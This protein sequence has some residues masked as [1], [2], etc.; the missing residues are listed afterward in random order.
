MTNIGLATVAVALLACLF[1]ASRLTLR[2]RVCVALALSAIQLYIP[3]GWFSLA[4][5]WCGATVLVSIVDRI[6]ERGIRGAARELNLA[7]WLLAFLAGCQ[8]VA[9]RWSPD[10]AQALGL[11]FD[12][13]WFTGLLLVIR[14]GLPRSAPSCRPLAVTM[15]LNG[16]LAGSLTVIC[17]L[18]PELERAWITSPAAPFFIGP[19]VQGI[20]TTNKNNIAD[21]AKAG[22][23]F[24][25]GNVASM[26][27]GLCV[28]ACIIAWCIRA[29][30][31]AASV[32][33]LMSA[34]GLVATGSKTGL[35]LFLLLHLALAAK[36]L[37]ARFPSQRPFFLSALPVIICVGAASVWAS[38]QVRK[39]LFSTFDD[40]LDLW[41]A[42]WKMFPQHPWQGLGFGG[43]IRVIGT[44]RK[45]GV[46]TYPPHNYVIAAWANAGLIAA[47]LT[48]AIALGWLILCLRAFVGGSF[49]LAAASMIP[50]WVLLHGLADNTQ[51]W[52]EVHTAS[53]VALSL[54]LVG[55]SRRTL[56]PHTD[57]TA[58]GVA[59]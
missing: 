32:C 51:L 50:L 1:I 14:T 53:V 58:N 29:N 35:L 26:Y 15:S 16:A 56:A 25:N 42:A 30:R 27:L 13:L 9:I 44:Y 52:G 37:S 23:F 17:R 10:K 28:V 54:A 31:L 24:V 47:V 34:I 18:S 57:P 5:L 22:G 20:Y 33:Y 6:R 12:V 7:E 3:G 48:V 4:Q 2:W 59:K 46:P 19:G 38:G 39:A 45:Y 49:V 21:P 8:L 43:W 11:T 41:W 40:R 36:W 55:A